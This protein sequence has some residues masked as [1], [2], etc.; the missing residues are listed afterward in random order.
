MI[1]IRIR[2]ADN[3]IDLRFPISENELYAK[4]AEIH[5]IDEKDAPSSMFVSKVYW[6][7]EFS[8]LEDRFANLDEL[9][10]LARRMESFDVLEMDQFLIAVTKADGPTEKDLI[11]LTFNL[12]KFTLVQDV[13][14]MGKIGRAYVMNTEGSVPAH[15]E[16][17]PKYA[18]IGKDLIDRR[19]AEITERGLLIRNL[20]D[21]LREVYDGQTFPEYYDRADYLVAVKA[22]YNGRSETL[23]LPDEELAIAKAFRRLQVPSDS[24]CTVSI[25]DATFDNDEW[26]ERIQQIID[27]EGIYEAN[28]MARAVNTADMDLAKLSA[29]VELTGVESAANIAFLAERIDYFNFIPGATCEDDVGQFLV[30]NMSCYSMNVEMEEFFDFTAFGEHIA[31]ENGGKFVAGGF[32]YYDGDGE[33]EELLEGLESEDEGMN[34]GGM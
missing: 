24:E 9:N 27:K 26:M 22:E 18:A 19:L 13:S 23:F 21:E 33:L 5:A 30:D 7:E 1:K 10:Y 6:P 31:E 32:V 3:G 11:N 14:S 12:D 20:F 25:T 34:M 29:V 8:M 16:D 15:D 17:D 4:L 28:K 2:N